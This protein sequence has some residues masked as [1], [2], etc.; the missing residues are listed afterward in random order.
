MSTTLSNNEITKIMS[1][2]FATNS[3]FVERFSYGLASWNFTLLPT[4]EEVVDITQTCSVL[5]RPS[6][7]NMLEQQYD[8]IMVVHSQ[9]YPDGTNIWGRN[10][11]H[12]IGQCVSFADASL[13]EDEND[14]SELIVH[15]MLHQYENVQN[16]RI[17]TYV[18]AEGV[19]GAEE[20]GFDDSGVDGWSTW[21]KLFMRGQV[22][23]ISSMRG[24]QNHLPVPVGSPEYFVGSFNSI[25]HGFTATD[26]ISH[27]YGKCINVA[28]GLSYPTL[29]SR[30]SLKNDCKGHSASFSLLA[31]GVL[32]HNLSGY[33][34]IP[35]NGLAVNNQ[36]AVLSSS[37]G[38]DA[39]SQFGLTQGGSLQHLASGRCL[40][41]QGG[42]YTDPDEGTLLLFHD[43]CDENRLKF[44]L[45]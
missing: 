37:C 27:F 1:N 10:G 33:C 26:T 25:M 18:G 44:S 9:K 3:N 43:G 42:G 7:A 32:Q 6:Y 20:H 17:Y 19:H 28:S 14:P 16:R 15:E 11:G 8:V 21:Y 31:N 40:H 39:A 22:A 12:S 36:Y 38:A 23:E 5:E 24:G 30:L 41:P 34:V 13:P 45:N 29:G 2:L 35:A 4:L